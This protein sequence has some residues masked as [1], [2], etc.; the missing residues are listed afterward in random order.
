MALIKIGCTLP[1][2]LVLE[3]K[4]T[5][6]T[7][8]GA[9]QNTQTTRIIGT[10]GMTDV[11]QAFWD[12]WKKENFENAA[13]K[14]GFIFEAKTEADIKAKTKDIEKNGFEQLDPDSH[15]VETDTN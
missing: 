10:H 9:N 6:V 1:H 14:N 3:V 15:G 4:G 8:A 13:F 7:L 12:A 2:G 11:D 5:F